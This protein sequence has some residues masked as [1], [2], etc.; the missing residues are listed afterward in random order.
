MTDISSHFEKAKREL[1]DERDT[2]VHQ[3]KDEIAQGK[4]RAL[5]RV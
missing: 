4:R 1:R 5:S 2:M 3:V